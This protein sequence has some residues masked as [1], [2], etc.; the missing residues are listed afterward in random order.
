MECDYPQ[1]VIQF[2]DLWVRELM[3]DWELGPNWVRT[4]ES[5]LI[6]S[7]ELNHKVEYRVHI[8]NQVQFL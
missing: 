7:L 5:T 3:L 8:H 4:S 2:H 6:Q 1:L